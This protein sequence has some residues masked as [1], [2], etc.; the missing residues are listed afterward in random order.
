MEQMNI[1][2]KDAET[3]LTAFTDIVGDN[4]ARGEPILLAV[5]GV[6]GRQVRSGARGN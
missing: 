6:I 1:H 3:F 4:F 5:D 2:T